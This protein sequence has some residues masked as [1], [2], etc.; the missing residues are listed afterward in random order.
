MPYTFLN[1]KRVHSYIPLKKGIY[2]NTKV[3]LQEIKIYTFID[4]TKKEANRECVYINILLNQPNTLIFDVCH[5]CI[6]MG[7]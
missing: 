7:R 6:I 2:T 1:A 3:K 4:I 5:K